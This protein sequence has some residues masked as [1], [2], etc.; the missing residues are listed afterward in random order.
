MCQISHEL[1]WDAWSALFAWRDKL[2]E[3]DLLD[4]F[5]SIEGAWYL[6]KVVPLEEDV[7]E[8]GSTKSDGTTAAKEGKEAQSGSTSNL[9]RI[10]YQGWPNK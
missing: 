7:D 3:G 4:V 1:L 10:H 9:V 5:N 6:G 2:G 8:E